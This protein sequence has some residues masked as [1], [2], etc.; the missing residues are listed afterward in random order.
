MSVRFD[1]VGLDPIADSVGL[2]VHIPFCDVRCP[3][4]HFYC[5]VNQD[6]ALPERYVQALRAEFSRLQEAGLIRRLRSVYFGGGTPTALRGAA[7]ASLCT[8]LGEELRPLCEANAEITIEANPESVSAQALAIWAQAGVNRVSLG[9]QSMHEP[10][11][12]FLGRL[13]TPDSNRKALD[14]ACAA[15]PRVS[16]DLIVGTPQSRWEDLAGGLDEIFRWPVGHVSAYLLE[17]HGETRFG[18]DFA[19]GKLLPQPDEEQC[20][21]YLAL[22]DALAARGLAAYELSNFARPNEEARHNS[23]YWTREPYLGLGASSHSF[24]HEHR[25][26]NHADARRYC[27][28][29]ESDAA[30]TADF[31]RLDER[32]RADERL[33]LGLR[34]RRGLALSELPESPLTRALCGEGLAQV[35]SERFRLSPAG[36]LLLDQIVAQ[37]AHSQAFRG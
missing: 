28:E 18:R 27:A 26:W 34:T 22:V 3:Y 30:P 35:D 5:F 29:L 16:I 17:L 33:L 6:A 7:H 36:W 4:C 8:W 15:V 21:I 32:A 20:A 14:V 10:T 19:R 2:Y 37:L 13:N 24:A 31:E 25:W 9:L 12:R 1:P 23:I 11:L